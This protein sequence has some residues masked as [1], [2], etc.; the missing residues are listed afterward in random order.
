MENTIDLPSACLTFPELQ[1]PQISRRNII[2]WL[3]D[4]FTND[5]KVIMV[6]GVDG[7]GKTTLL[8]QFA[9]TFP[10]RS[11]CFFVK[12]DIWSCDPQ[13]YLSELCEQMFIA[14]YNKP[15]DNELPKDF[16][17]IKQYFNKLYALLAKKGRLQERPYYFVI[18]GLEWVSE[19]YGQESI[20]ELLPSDP[21]SGTFLLISSSNDL[22]LNFQ[23]ETIA[24]EFLAPVE[25]D[26][27]L[28]EIG[29]KDKNII[30]SIYDVCKGMPGYLD[31]IRRE[32]TTGIPLEDITNNL[33]K[34]FHELLEREWVRVKNSNQSVVDALCIS[35]YSE[36]P[37]TVNDLSEIT[38]FSKKDL[39]NC[40]EKISFLE[41]SAS[42]QINFVTDA[43]KKFLAD[44]LSGRKVWAESELIRFYE[45]DPT[46]ENAQ[47]QLPILY[48]N[49]DQ[50]DALKSLVSVNNLTSLLR[51]RHEFIS[52]RKTVRV[53]ADAAIIKND[54]QTLITYSI[55][56]SAF[57]T[58]SIASPIYSE[59]E[60]VLE[61][62][63]Y[64]Q[65]VGI[66]YQAVLS[67]DRLE[68]LS[69][70]CNHIKSQGEKIPSDVISEIDRLV[71][72]INLHSSSVDRIM[73]IAASLFY[74]HSQA[75]MDLT[76]K[77]SQVNPSGRSMDMLISALTY[78][79]EDDD[80]DKAENDIQS[81]SNRLKMS[82]Q[83]LIQFIQVSS[84]LIS[85]LT[86]DEVIIEADK[87]KD[88][89]ASLFM[90][91]SWCNS[92]RTNLDAFKVVKHALELMTASP[93]TP[94][95]LH[96]RQFAEP[97]RA[98]PMEELDWLIGR[99]DILKDTAIKK[100]FEEI[101]RLELLLASV[102]SRISKELGNQ[103]LLDTY[104]E[105]LKIR[106]LDVL[107]YCYTRLLL[108]LPLI[109][110]SDPLQLKQDIEIRLKSEFNNLLIN[111]ADHFTITK[112]ILREITSYDPEIA[113]NFAEQLNTLSRRDDAYTE[114]LIAYMRQDD[115]LINLEFIERILF[116][117]KDRQQRDRTFV[118]ILERFSEKEFFTKESHAY[119]FMEIASKLENPVDRSLA[120][121]YCILI[122]SNVNQSKTAD[123]L[124]DQ[125]INSWQSIDMLWQKV[126][127]GFEIASILSKKNK[128]QAENIL[129]LSRKE[130]LTSPLACGHVSELYINT[131]I[132]A[133]RCFTDLLKD[134]EYPKYRSKLLEAIE[135]IP[136]L[137]IKCRL[138][139]DLALRH[140]L[141][142]K[143]QDFRLLMNEYILRTLEFCKDH[144][145]DS[146]RANI[147]TM[148]SP[149]LFE[150]ERSILWL[151]VDQLDYFQKHQALLGVV[152]YILSGRSL[153]DPI[154][155]KTFGDFNTI[156]YPTTLK[157]C[158]V[159]EHMT[160]DFVI[161]RCI[162][163]L[164]KMI[165]K[166][167]SRNPD[168][169]KCL[170]NERQAL[171]ISNII[172]K[173][174][175]KLPDEDNL[176]HDGYKILC[177]A[178][179]AKLRV[180]AS[181]KAIT[182][183]Q[184][185][186][187]GI[188]M[189]I[190]MA[191]SIPNV[192]DRIFVMTL[193]AETIEKN[194]PAHAS[195][196]LKE[197]SELINKIPCSLDQGTRLQ[198][199]ADIWR[200]LK[201]INSAKYFLKESMTVLQNWNWD[202][203]RDEVTSSILQ[204]AHSIDPEF[205]ASLTSM[206]DNPVVERGMERFL[207][208]EE[209]KNHP[210]KGTVKIGKPEDIPD[211][212]GR[213]AYKLLESLCSGQNTAIQTPEKILPWLNEAFDATYRDAFFITAW[214]I[215]ND[216]L[217]NR[218]LYSSRLQN[219]FK[220]LLDDL[221]LFWLAGQIFYGS[222]DTTKDLLLKNPSIPESLQLYKVGSSEDAISDLTN[223]LNNN[224]KDYLKIYDA[225][226]TPKDLKLL[227]SLPHETRV[228]ILSQ[229]KSQ[230]DISDD[231]RVIESYKRI[232]LEMFAPDNL[233]IYIHILGTKKNGN[234]PIHDRYYVT[235]GGKG[236]QTGTSVSGLGNKDSFIRSM[237]TE[238]VNAIEADSIDKL[239]INPPY[240]Y[241]DER[242]C[243]L[244]FTLR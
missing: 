193:V 90:L 98:A 224:V 16:Y 167:E 59:V 100:P 51:H 32:F 114:V 182:Q 29:I 87:I 109:D 3:H 124:F 22:G 122:K 188:N 150:Y 203:S 137:E 21:L 237:A 174:I 105:I 154:N 234:G 225:Y 13:R 123:G 168:H 18:D 12:R 45:N 176:K 118:R 103:R 112:K 39:R 8:A 82:N 181:T 69:K 94:S 26:F 76:E 162:S 160:S 142:G 173:I 215:E 134:K 236:I 241:K 57:K 232:F 121:S 86:P 38:N 56:G 67:E 147:I 178:E 117:I 187:P 81:D 37:I 189:I 68:L 239:L 190:N 165:V 33:P 111:T 151:E 91:R 138:I 83:S 226:F 47:T 4:R 75:A 2:D 129:V 116:R 77:I 19:T 172:I 192:A 135:R 205:A 73:K 180:S 179:L 62:G 233:E 49:T 166:A 35:T 15:I 119:R 186:I 93:Y 1:N 132:L 115:N 96:L 42:E 104:I 40:I 227:I 149:C 113:I 48:R 20:V 74:I 101:I 9:N 223:W 34:G 25:V 54:L 213:A 65:A 229:R 164:I 46:N 185:I 218:E 146:L 71:L 30:N 204:Q 127:I 191:K 175:Q 85:K 199:I 196:L 243:A 158:E 58:M 27:Y 53:A 106:E 23:Y 97:L 5:R 64:Q 143:D 200:N 214:S 43:H 222:D 195:Q 125:V 131:I 235:A 88:L 177:L 169:L 159:L 145:L 108:S 197:A 170:L 92:N 139:A 144:E 44:K 212:R 24:I 28:K 6:Q 202:S 157:V 216:L 72:E 84:P 217:Q 153:S 231:T 36:L 155:E 206:V 10:D 207:I 14:I 210:E 221:Q 61:L 220:G 242:L 66:A 120:L 89:S 201:D 230:V 238:E 163:D 208:V 211:A 99:F 183:W 41:I 31:Q 219:T 161:Y 133:I 194:E 148:I 70:I 156:D 17:Q 152:R 140:F 7:A 102:E 55:L 95:M 128:D 79:L 240:F 60:A 107:C 244:T 130:R 11:I 126:D 52:L 171:T 110:S 228:Y 141:A 78:N 80:L 63:N 50:Y 198:K 184:N 209:L 136:S